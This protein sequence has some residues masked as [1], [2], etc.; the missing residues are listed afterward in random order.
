MA[1]PTEQL[2]VQPSSPP[3][4]PVRRRFRQRVIRGMGVLV[5]LLVIAYAIRRLPFVVRGVAAGLEQVSEP[6]VRT[7]NM[8]RGV[9]DSARIRPT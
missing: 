4:K 5:V 7:L 8:F 3:G 2:A 6:L 9:V 1:F